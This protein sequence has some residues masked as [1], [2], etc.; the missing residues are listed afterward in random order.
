MYEIAH[1]SDKIKVDKAK[2][3]KG[4]KLGKGVTWVNKIAKSEKELSEIKKTFGFH[5]LAIEDC[6]GRQQRPKIEIFDEYILIIIKQLEL[7]SNLVINQ[8]GLFIGKDY[9]VTISNKHFP[10]VDDVRKNLEKNGKTIT[11]DLVAYHILD[12]IVDSYFPILDGVE[13]EIETVEK[14]IVKNPE[15]QTIS[16]NIFSVRRKLLSLR[17]ATWPA[18]EIFSAL[19]KADLP[20]ISRKNQVYFRDI[21]DHTI[22]VIDLVETY[23]ELIS[24]A[25]ETHMSSISNSLNEVMKVLTVI[26]TIFIP[27]TFITGLYGMNFE[28]MPEIA[29]EYGYPFSLGLMLIIAIGM[30]MYFKKKKWV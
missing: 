11:P 19:S 2:T 23:R 7:K 13:S 24:G 17:K 6:V 28:V 27:L 8:L 20:N 14:E 12:K 25:L 9:V 15:R 30:L 29:W 3:L 4:L 18:R 1:I 22:Q 26:A 21:Y 10:E 16:S 5:K